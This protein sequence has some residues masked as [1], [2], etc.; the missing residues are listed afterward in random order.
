MM[1]TACSPRS[2][3]IGT[4]QH[5][6]HLNDEFIESSVMYRA[7]I[8]DTTGTSNIVRPL[9]TVHERH[10]LDEMPEGQDSSDEV[11]VFA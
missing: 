1:A 3:Q 9:F 5:Q 8:G 2:C 4:R 7:P 11:R 6:R 10:A